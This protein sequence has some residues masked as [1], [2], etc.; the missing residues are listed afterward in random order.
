[1]NGVEVV[2]WC[3]AIAGLLVAGFLVGQA[4]V[5]EWLARREWDRMVRES[6]RREEAKRRALAGPRSVPGG[7]R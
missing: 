2:G 5:D 3:V 7:R 1:M 4:E 6:V